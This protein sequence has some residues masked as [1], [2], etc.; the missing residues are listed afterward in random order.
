MTTA[1][2]MMQIMNKLGGCGAVYVAGK[3]TVREFNFSHESTISGAI[4]QHENMLT[5]S[6]PYSF[7]LFFQGYL[8]SWQLDLHQFQDSFP[9][10]QHCRPVH[11]VPV[12]RGT[13]P[14]ISIIYGTNQLT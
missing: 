8:V 12:C 2:L 11:G 14:S 10:Q 9:P 4:M 5:E 13:M 7:C 1:V 6:I 3:S